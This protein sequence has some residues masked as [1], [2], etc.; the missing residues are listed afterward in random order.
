M[1]LIQA[2]ELRLSPPHLQMYTVSPI[3]KP[4]HNYPC[5]CS[6]ECVIR[7]ANNRPGYS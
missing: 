2:L 7:G 5:G 6:L 4:N 1:G 3:Q